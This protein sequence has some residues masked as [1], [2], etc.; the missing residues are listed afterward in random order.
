MPRM[1]LYY[2]VSD[3]IAGTA[4]HLLDYS[5]WNAAACSP[6]SSPKPVE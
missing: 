4:T 5:W 6:F 2:C 1:L 3:I